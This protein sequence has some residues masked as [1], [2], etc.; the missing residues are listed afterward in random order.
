LD[1]ALAGLVSDPRPEWRQVRKD[2]RSFGVAVGRYRID[3]PTA[4]S[5]EDIAPQHSP[6]VLHSARMP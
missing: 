2:P 5:V 6:P 3:A 4:L 1:R